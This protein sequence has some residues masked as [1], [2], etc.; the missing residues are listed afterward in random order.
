MNRL[1]EIGFQRVGTWKGDGTQASCTLQV[2]GTTR[3]VLY[4]FVEGDTVCYVGKTSR[5][6]QERMAGYEN[7]GSSQSTNIR[8]N[9]EIRAALSQSL[10]V[11]ILAFVDKSDLRKGMFRINLVDGLE[12]D[13][14]RQLNPPW[15]KLG[16]TNAP[17]RPAST[18]ASIDVPRTPRIEAPSKEIGHPRTQ[19]VYAPPTFKIQL[20]SA[21]FNQGFFNI[22]VQYDEYVGRDQAPIIIQL[23]PDGPEIDGWINRK[24]NPNGTPRIMGGKMLTDWIQSNFRLKGYVQVEVLNHNAIRLSKPT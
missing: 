15:N 21:Y 13:I 18:S 9:Q 6:L 7:P 24:A 1:S 11:D 22:G 16:T 8:V 23:G 19:S 20:G 14:I 3:H 10:A 12:A 17:L 5:T 2:L 4:A